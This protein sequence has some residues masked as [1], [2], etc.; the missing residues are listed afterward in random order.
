M[1]SY[2]DKVMLGQFS[3]KLTQEGVSSTNPQ[4]EQELIAMAAESAD[5]Q[6]FG[7]ARRPALRR[8]TRCAFEDS[9]THSRKYRWRFLAPD[10]RGTYN[11]QSNL[12]SVAPR[13]VRQVIVG[14]TSSR[15]TEHF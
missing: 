6:K 5:L 7:E 8:V 4:A 3:V 12:H 15:A 2:P 13:G 9:W 14:P 11:H 1:L 10:L